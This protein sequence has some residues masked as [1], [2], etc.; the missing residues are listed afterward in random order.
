METAER[1][2]LPGL[3]APATSDETEMQLGSSQQQP[4]N[5]YLIP[6]HESYL[7]SGQFVCLVLRQVPVQALYE[8]NGLAPLTMFSLLPFENKLSV[9]HA[10]ISRTSNYQE[11][12]KSKV[13][14][15][16][17]QCYVLSANLTCV[18]MDH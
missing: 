9:L 13:K 18:V 7:R 12:I 15:D 17:A 14:V 5:P 1:T 4:T 16:S 3:T 6:Q 8:R 2:A 11:P 10:S